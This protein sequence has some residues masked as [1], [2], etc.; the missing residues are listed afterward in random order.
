M[1]RDLGKGPWGEW[2]AQSSPIPRQNDCL[3][4]IQHHSEIALLPEECGPTSESSK[5][6]FPQNTKLLH[7]V[8]G[9]HLNREIVPLDCLYALSED[10]ALSADSENQFLNFMQTQLNWAMRYSEKEESLSLDTLTYNRGLLDDHGIYLQSIITLLRSHGGPDWP[11]ATLEEH[12]VVVQKMRETLLGDFEFLFSESQRLS[13]CYVEGA[14]TIRNR[15]SLRQ[16]RDAYTQGLKVKKL[17]L[18]AFIFMSFQF[19]CA[20]LS[21]GLREFGNGNL[22]MGHFFAVLLPVLAVSAVSMMSS[23]EWQQLGRYFE[24]HFKEL[25]GRLPGWALRVVPL[26]K[27]GWTKLYISFRALLRPTPPV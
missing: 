5:C 8:Y 23:T 26:L 18:A 12:V 21:M 6:P 11:R 4:L 9:S 25:R 3:A 16:S 10:F 13:S 19:T 27:V 22:N 2:L 14:S 7:K 15:A 1:G 17:T 24:S 20:F